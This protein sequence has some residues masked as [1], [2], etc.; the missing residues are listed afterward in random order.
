MDV[1]RLLR[2]APTATHLYQTAQRAAAGDPEALAYLKQQGWTE[3]LEIVRPGYG[4]TGRQVVGHV[5]EAARN[6]EDALRQARGYVDAEYTVL[7]D[8]PWS[9]FLRGLLRMRYG[10]HIILGPV[11]TGKTTLALRLA[12]RVSEAHGY[13]VECV[14]MYLED[15]PPFGVSIS[16]ET[17]VKRMARLGRYLDAQAEGDEEAES[18]DLDLFGEPRARGKEEPASLPP[19][20]RVIIVDEASLGMSNSPGDPGRRAAMQ[21]LAQCRHLDW[22][23]IWIGQWAG[24]LPLPLLG[25]TTVWVKRP[26]GREDFTDRDNPAVRDLWRRAREAFEGLR[27]SPW[28]VEP[29]L[30]MRSWAYCDCKSLAGGPGY[31][32]L[33]PFTPAGKA[34]PEEETVDGELVD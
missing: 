24:Q 25:Q 15:V 11:G 6:I 3:A 12:Q 27:G 31:S 1:L 18:E 10:G 16:R 14:N 4:E 9:G 5:R 19:T 33:I 21:A 30:D 13:R 22:V 17:L 7:E 26:D 20:E 34:S 23:V 32:G 2:M 29:W 8:P 28:H